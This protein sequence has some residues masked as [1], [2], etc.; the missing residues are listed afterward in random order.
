MIILDQIRDHLSAEIEGAYISTIQ[1][2]GIQLEQTKTELNKL[3]SELNGRMKEYSSELAKKDQIID[4]IQLKS[5][6]ELTALRKERDLLQQHLRQE[7]EKDTNFEQ[8]RSRE[9]L[10]YK[11][12]LDGTQAQPVV[13]TRCE[14][15][16]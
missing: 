16:P 6:K 8:N 9:I 13:R 4:E 2:L 15:L 1:Q 11:G 10:Q 12:K 7:N 14:A 3:R 5:E